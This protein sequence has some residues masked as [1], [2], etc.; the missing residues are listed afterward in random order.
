MARK[1]RVPVI[2]DASAAEIETLIAQLRARDK[3]PEYADAPVLD[4]YARISPSDDPT[5]TK[6][7]RQT[8][9]VLKRLLSGHYRLGQALVDWNLSAWSPRGKRP[10]F[11][12][13]LE[14]MASGETS[15]IAVWLSDRLTRQM[16]EAE[17]L[18]EAGARGCVILS[19]SGEYDLSTSDGRLALR[20]QT[21]FAQQES[22]RKSERL[23]RKYKAQR[24]GEGHNDGMGAFSRVTWFGHGGA[25]D[26][27]LRVERDAIA[28]GIDAIIEGRSWAYVANE[29]NRR[30]VRTRSGQQFK[31][32]KVTVLLNRPAHAGYLTKGEGANRVI[33]G[34]ARNVTPIV[35]EDTWQRFTAVLAG[36]K[37]GRKGRTPGSAR[38]FLLG[39]L[40]R[41]G[42][43]AINMRC[44]EAMYRCNPTNG[45]GAVHVNAQ[46]LD[47]AVRQL[48]I[49]AMSDPANAETQRV[50]SAAAARINAAIADVEARQANILAAYQ[51]G[52]LPDTVFADSLATS[53]QELAGLRAQLADLGDIS[54]AGPVLFSAARIT[55]WWDEATDEE[56]RR[57]VRVAFPRGVVVMPSPVKRQRMSVEL[58]MDR[59][60]RVATD[61]WLRQAQATRD[62]K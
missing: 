52:H 18:I 48:V 58:A 45:C 9:D 15:G 22:D 43:C 54:D 53:A 44:S 32:S 28:W 46:A 19:C 5:A 38:G 34:R 61:E 7:E 50:T 16:H 27:T 35:S 47:A 14:R 17:R 40:A 12:Y 33:V 2:N 42:A 8:I 49:E 4:T 62:A 41:C 57:L 59:V 56:R 20:M 21:A 25:D 3:A 11:L 60:L 29:W 23:R 37:G 39:G 55:Q 51:R 24:E 26:A 36:R 10:Q 1:T 13:G 31:I 30:G 6:V